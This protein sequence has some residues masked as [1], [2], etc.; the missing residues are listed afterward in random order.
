MPVDECNVHFF[1][2]L[3][4]F[5][6][7]I[8]SLFFFTVSFVFMYRLSCIMH[9]LLL[10]WQCACVPLLIFYILIY[11]QG[12]TNKKGPDTP[13]KILNFLVQF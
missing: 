7:L 11:Y 9:E 8:L 3:L 5:N 2:V 4:N 13:E 12:K 10:Y 6:N 1:S